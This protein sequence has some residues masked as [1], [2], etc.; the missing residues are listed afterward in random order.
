MQRR[1]IESLLWVVTH[2]CSLQRPTPVKLGRE[3]WYRHFCCPLNRLKLHSKYS[4]FPWRFPG[5]IIQT[6]L[7]GWALT[8][9]RG[10]INCFPEFPLCSAASLLPRQAR[11]TLRNLVTKPL[12][13]VS[14]RHSSS[15]RIFSAPYVFRMPTFYLHWSICSSSNCRVMPLS[16]MPT[17]FYRSRF[18]D[19]PQR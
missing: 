11:V 9:V 13:Q 7:L 15:L 2:T 3:I 12:T 18:R 8:W 6:H 19:P 4:L 16:L 14:A 10:F 17:A 1:W 5:Y